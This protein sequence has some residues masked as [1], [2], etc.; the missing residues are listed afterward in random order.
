MLGREPLVRYLKRSTMIPADKPWA[1]H[2]LTF[3]PFPLLTS[4]FLSQ[5]LSHL[6]IF[7]LS[8]CAPY[9]LPKT[10]PRPPS[11]PYPSSKESTLRGRGFV[12]SPLEGAERVPSDPGV[13]GVVECWS[14]GVMG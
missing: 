7:L 6:P 12:W 2:P 14:T 10:D 11:C 1:A 3:L 8:H 5:K 9:P 13:D 4:H